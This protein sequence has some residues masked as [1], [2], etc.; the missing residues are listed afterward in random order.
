MD[1][2]SQISS[3]AKAQKDD[4]DKS[5]KICKLKKIDEI[6]SHCIFYS[7]QRQDSKETLR[8]AKR[9]T[10]TCWMESGNLQKSVVKS[11]MERNIC[12]QKSLTRN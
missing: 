2:L 12:K 10:K 3:E 7:F 9:D 1:E 6:E 4:S 5:M 8:E 11:N